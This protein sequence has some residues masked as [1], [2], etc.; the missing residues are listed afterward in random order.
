MTEKCGICGKFIKVAS[1]D[2]TRLCPTHSILLKD[3]NKLDH[4][5]F[6]LEQSLRLLEKSDICRPLYRMRC[7]LGEIQQAF[8]TGHKICDY[9]TT[10]ELIGRT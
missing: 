6:E 9:S 7:N 2:N 1:W 8:K 3:F 10:L 5:I 4:L